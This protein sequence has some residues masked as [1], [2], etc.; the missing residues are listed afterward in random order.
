MSQSVVSGR[1]TD[2]LL[3]EL[4]EEITDKLQKGEPVDLEAHIQ[5]HPERADELRKLLPALH[6]LAVAGSGA[7]ADDAPERSQHEE[8]PLCGVLGDFRITHEVG[9]GGM[10]IVYEAEQISLGRR[11]ALKILPFAST[12]DPKQLQRFKNE[13]QAAAGLHH[14]N[15]V[16]VYAT[17]CERG[18]HFYAMQFIDGQT[19]AHVIA[20][21]RI[22]IADLK[23]ERD[24][25]P[26]VANGH[27][28]PD[29]TASPS[30][31]EPICTLK[32]AVCN[33][34][35]AALLTEATTTDRAFFRTVAK[36]GIQ[37]A[38]ALEQAHQLGVIHRDIKPANLLVDGRGNLW[39][40]DFGLAHCQSQVGL[41]MSGDLVG[42]LRYM[43][44]EQALAK[45]VIVDH[46]TDIYSLGA[47]LYEL[48]SLEP[49]FPGNDRQ[50]L[51]RQIAFEEPRPP[52]RLNNAVPGELETIVLK[53]MEKNPHERYP[54]AQELA[55]DL[56]RFLK[57][58]PIRARRPGFLQRTQK[59]ARRHKP[60]MAAAV[61]ILLTM[62]LASGVSSVLVWSAYRSE[63]RAHEAETEQRRVGEHR[64]KL[65]R[66]R[67]AETSAVLGFFE[68]K[69][70]GA[71]RPKDQAGGQGHDITLADAIRAALPYV[72]KS[73]TAQP[74]IE[75]RLRMAM[76]ISFH[77][78]SD[79]K[80][81]CEQLEAARRL[82]VTH[83]G[84]DQPETL[85]CMGN[86]A[87]A[88]AYSGRIQ[89][90]LKLHEET[91]RLRKAKLG[92]D[93][94][95]TLK[96]R[97]SVAA[98][99]R[100][101]PGRSQEAFKLFEETLQL[102]QAKLG[103]DHPDTLASMSTLAESYRNVGR[104]DE[105]LKLQEET[106]RLWKAKL[107]P[108]HP[109]TLSS[110]DSL[111]TCYAAVG[112][113]QEA[114]EL[115]EETLRLRRA[116]LGPNHRDTLRTMDNL[117]ISYA[118]GRRQD[119]LKLFEETLRLREISLGRDHPD[120]L[121]S[122][123]NLA[124]CYDSAGLTQEALK[125]HEKT[126]RLRKSKLGPDNGATLQSMN[127]LA[128][129]YF[130]VGDADKALALLHDTLTLRERRVEAEPG[131]SLEQSRLAWTHGQI[132]QAKEARQDYA[133]AVKAYANS[134]E[135]FGKLDQAGALKAPF[136]RHRMTHYQQRLAFCR[137]VERAV[138][139]LSFTLK[140]P[141]EEVPRFL[142]VRV[143]F[144]LK[145]HELSAAVESAAKMKELAGD[146]AERLYDA[147][148]AYALCAGAKDPPSGTARLV[149]E[150]ADEAMAILN[151][152]VAKGWKNVAHIKRDK[153][154]DALRA[155]EDFQ[156]LL[157]NLEARKKD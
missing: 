13:A 144:F 47:T 81:A 51:L 64:E 60:L 110:M 157:S 17:G 56:E 104:V 15:I 63:A 118:A 116:E 153:D 109:D 46:R 43:S 27:H 16:P 143:R 151:Q 3:A 147:A 12:L 122:M 145:G 77:Y 20:D 40:T 126:L 97:N 78:L 50:E 2:P 141:A 91:L 117:A 87:I 111:A 71:A 11:V 86:L 83:H 112:R 127:N 121:S 55:E 26:S 146:K 119:A 58:E 4:V 84:L 88:Y 150:C 8:A 154:L 102:Q 131:N 7:G 82:Y 107:G 28:D 103:R 61:A 114:L 95:E 115:R 18:V 69:I 137:K 53:A 130:A 34:T 39:V 124:T 113:A 125:L 120:V 73:F 19:L 129:S 44:P 30:R 5:Q 37:A 1:A 100:L 99:L 108:N 80:S 76:G 32:S 35:E 10:G 138:K 74:L 94:P 106:L 41:T 25:F 23:D 96:G 85:A 72:D 14:T 140:Q 21:L 45:R 136:F 42:T 29:A 36:L 75:A 67:E 156:K 65:A 135:M 54:T 59:W 105:A 48:L 98:L 22:Q 148:C 79:A 57:D 92:N 134:V 89:E 133:L 90:S 33:S 128:N 149:K 123:N 68:S 6:M 155:R 24:R 152:A 62:A 142:D 52:R 139:D 66:E 70:I 101:D 93:H 132:G 49:A 9:R 31:A 38:Q